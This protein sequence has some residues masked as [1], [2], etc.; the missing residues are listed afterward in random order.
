MEQDLGPDL[1]L[2]VVQPV[3]STITPHRTA[4]HRL[5]SL[6]VSIFASPLSRSQAVRVGWFLT[7]T[8]SDSSKLRK[9]CVSVRS[10]A[11]KWESIYDKK[12]W[13]GQYVRVKCEWSGLDSIFLVLLSSHSD[14]V[15]CGLARPSL[16]F[17]ALPPLPPPSRS[18]K[19]S[20]GA[21]LLSYAS[22]ALA[23]LIGSC[24]TVAV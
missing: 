6:S 14:L 1:W 15:N 8:L 16:E 10:L 12:L 3:P 9:G 23:S 2:G 21:C 22:C 20:D 18:A 7:Y 17:V 24:Q 13:Q 5:P 11:N 19:M 4:V